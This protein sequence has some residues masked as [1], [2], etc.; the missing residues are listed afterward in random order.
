MADPHPTTLSHLLF[1]ERV[2]ISFIIT[3]YCCLSLTALPSPMKGGGSVG[4]RERRRR[5]RRRQRLDD[6]GKGRTCSSRRRKK[7]SFILEGNVVW[8][9]VLRFSYRL[10]RSM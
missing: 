9:E 7:G 10:C 6:P 4:G 3:S 8:L 2:I 1:R 5:R